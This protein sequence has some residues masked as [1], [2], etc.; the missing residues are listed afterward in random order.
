M[1]ILCRSAKNEPRK[2][3]G[4]TPLNPAPQAAQ[5]FGAFH[6]KCASHIW[7]TRLKG[8]VLQAFAAGAESPPRLRFASARSR[9]SL[10]GIVQPRLLHLEVTD[11]K[12]GVVGCKF[13][14]GR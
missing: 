11:L 7:H 14:F 9:A 8:V 1:F 12:M 4:A 13:L 2:R 3:V 6:T 10:K 5:R